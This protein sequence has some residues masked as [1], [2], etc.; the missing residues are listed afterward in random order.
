MSFYDIFSR[1][2]FIVDISIPEDNMFLQG[3]R[4]AIDRILSNFNI[5]CTTLWKVYRVYIVG[6]IYEPLPVK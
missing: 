4:D 1:K 6:T 2:N 5:Q 3:E